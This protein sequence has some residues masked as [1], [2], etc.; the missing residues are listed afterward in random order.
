MCWAPLQPNPWAEFQASKELWNS[1]FVPGGLWNS[2]S[3]VWPHVTARPRPCTGDVFQRMQEPGS[4]KR[5]GDLY[6]SAFHPRAWQIMQSMYLS[7]PLPNASDAFNLCRARLQRM[8]TAILIRAGEDLSRVC[9]RINARMPA[10]KS[11]CIFTRMHVLSP[12]CLHRLSCMCVY[13]CMN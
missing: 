6:I 5:F 9:G 4:G 12:M 3:V 10:I 7:A 13:A 11:A 1:T 2:T 8:L